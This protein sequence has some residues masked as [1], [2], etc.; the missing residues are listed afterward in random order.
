MGSM[1]RR[2]QK[3]RETVLMQGYGQKNDARNR[4][5]AR[6][7]LKALTRGLRALSA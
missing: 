4:K 1:K 6:K 2:L 7:F 5:A 3:R